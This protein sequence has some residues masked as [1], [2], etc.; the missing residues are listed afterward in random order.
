[1]GNLHL[2]RSE[3]D[4]AIA[5]F[6]RSPDQGFRSAR[7][8]LGVIFARGD[9]VEKDAEAAFEWYGLAAAQGHATA[10]FN[11][12]VFYRDGLGTA[13]DGRKA[14]EWFTRSAENGNVFA[15]INLARIYTLGNVAPKDLTHA[16]MWLEI[17]RNPFGPQS[18]RAAGDRIANVRNSAVAAKRLLE[19]QIATAD[20][21]RAEDRARNWLGK[22]GITG[23]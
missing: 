5:Y 3:T 16:Y 12:G 2:Q 8:N 23:K 14:V 6:R 13:A 22:F 21:A 1:M 10:Q 15:Q 19:E 11:L 18:N 9:G 17:A 20:I 4:K 7:Y